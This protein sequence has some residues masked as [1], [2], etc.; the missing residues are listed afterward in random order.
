MKN[1][2]GKKKFIAVLIGFAL[3]VAMSAGA[4]GNTRI[5]SNLSV[6]PSH[7]SYGTVFPEEVLFQ[8]ILIKLSSSFLQNNRLDDVEYSIKQKIKPRNPRDASYCQR[9]PNN[10]TRCYPTL[11]PYLSKEPDGIPGNDTGVAAFH[12]PTASSSIAHGRLAK[13]DND[14]QDPWV[15]DLH[16]P[17]F[18]GQC[19]QDNVVPQAY[20][21]NP[22]LEGEM[23]GCSLEVVVDKVSR[24][25][26]ERE[27][28][29]DKGDKGDKE[30]K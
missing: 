22:A 9:H 24:V 23:F 20:E 5:N 6:S 21:V 16:V 3:F 15:I 10:L 27:G 26:R 12:D 14:L 11:C 2:S 30:D 7:L 8:P 18:K 28:K 4:T 19:A 17:C 29:G 1:F 13:S 25:Q